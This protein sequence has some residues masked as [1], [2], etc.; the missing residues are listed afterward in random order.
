M[1]KNGNPIPLPRSPL[2]PKPGAAIALSVLVLYYG[3]HARDRRWGEPDEDENNCTECNAYG[4]THLDPH[5]PGGGRDP[6]QVVQN[7]T[8]SPVEWS[9]RNIADLAQPWQAPI[10]AG[11]TDRCD[12]CLT[13]GHVAAYCQEGDTDGN[14]ENIYENVDVDSDVSAPEQ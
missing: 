3:H 6:E 12:R 9:A 5:V 10:F 8:P 11:A 7:P 4:A 1:M 13:V 14:N 2:S